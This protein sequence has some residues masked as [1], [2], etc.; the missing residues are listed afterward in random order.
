M[1]AGGVPGP[2]AELLLPVAGPVLHPPIPRPLT[3]T[4]PAQVHGGQALVQGIYTFLL[5]NTYIMM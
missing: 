4:Q 1:Q 2:G 3:P 5:N